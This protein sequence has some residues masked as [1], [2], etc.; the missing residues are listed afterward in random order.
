MTDIKNVLSFIGMGVGII[1][2]INSSHSILATKETVN[3]IEKYQLDDRREIKEHIKE[4]KS[5][6]KTISR[7]LNEGY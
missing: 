4:I 5:E 7:K 6:L 3:R 2:L 1:V